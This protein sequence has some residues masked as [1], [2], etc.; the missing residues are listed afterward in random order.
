M[1]KTNSIKLIISGI[2]A[3]LSAK[4]G[5]LYPVLMFLLLSMIIDYGTG[6]ISAGYNHEIQSRRGMW[7]IIKKAMYGVVVAVAMITDWIIINVAANIGIDVPTSTFFGLLV[8]IWLIFNE[9]VSILENLIKMEVPL[10]GF[11]RSI[12]SKF[13]IVVENQGDKVIESIKQE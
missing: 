11:L 3:F 13:K 5:L 6:M 12:V 8:A 4:L 2:G 1:D 9:L 7:G 10:P